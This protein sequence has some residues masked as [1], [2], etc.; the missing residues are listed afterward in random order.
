VLLYVETLMSCHHLTLSAIFRLPVGAGM[1]LLEAR[2]TRMALDAGREAPSGGH[3]D[4][5]VA[6]ARARREAEIRATHDVLP[7]PSR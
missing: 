1:A 3:I 4:R 6:S 7:N 2:R 5:A